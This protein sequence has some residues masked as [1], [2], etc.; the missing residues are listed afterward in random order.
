MALQGTWYNGMGSELRINTD[1]DMIYG[2]YTIK[3]LGT[4]GEFKVAGRLNNNPATGGI[5]V[6]FVVVWHNTYTDRQ[7]VTSWSG[8]YQK[9]NGREEI[10]T[11]WL[12]TQV[13]P[14]PSDWHS[15]L[16]GHDVFLREEPSAE[17]IAIRE[18]RGPVSHP[19]N[20]R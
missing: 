8:Q 11:S 1:G 18:R 2:T 3:G 7:C 6:G 16:V 19:R 14:D 9:V 15:T 20:G 4:A 13:T 5:A 17:E 10:I 12:L